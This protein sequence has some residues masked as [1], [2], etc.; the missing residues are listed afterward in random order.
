[1][2]KKLINTSEHHAMQIHHIESTS[3]R[4]RHRTTACSRRRVAALT[5]VQLF[6]VASVPQVVPFSSAAQL[7]RNVR[8]LMQ[9]TGYYKGTSKKRSTILSRRISK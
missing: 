8:L 1:M 5:W 3:T 7:R 4:N 2:N 6:S 9:H